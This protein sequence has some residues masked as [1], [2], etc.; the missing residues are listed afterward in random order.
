MGDV[1]LLCLHTFIVLFRVFRPGGVRSVLAESV[2]L[3]HQLLILNRSRRRAPH[4]RIS[5]RFFAGFCSL[6]VKPIRLVRA[7]SLRLY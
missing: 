5:D 4:L 2:L 7:G 1:I 3:K 6:F